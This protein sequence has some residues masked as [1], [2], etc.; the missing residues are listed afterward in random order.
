MLCP[1]AS[2]S[3]EGVQSDGQDVG[4]D[5]RNRPSPFTVP[6]QYQTTTATTTTTPLG[7]RA[8]GPALLILSVVAL[9]V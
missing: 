3:W 6:V 2:F 9:C 5:Q 7:R 1:T 8:G 4:G